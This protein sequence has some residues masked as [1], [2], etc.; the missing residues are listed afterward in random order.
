MCRDV[1]KLYQLRL[2]NNNGSQIYIPSNRDQQ[3]LDLLVNQQIGSLQ[4]LTPS[5][6]CNE[7][8]IPLICFYYFGLCDS[9]GEVLLP[10]AT[11]CET[12][13]NKTCAR[14]FQM[15]VTTLG[16]NVLPQC[17]DLPPISQ[18]NECAGKYYGYMSDRVCVYHT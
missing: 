16:R 6:E 3:Q 9:S 17:E 13:S 4:L 7:A 12:V 11:Q 10:S 2:T 1:L 15:A 18:F 14:E 5:P 8:A